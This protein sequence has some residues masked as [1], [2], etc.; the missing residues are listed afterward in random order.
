MSSDDQFGPDVAARYDDDS[1]AMFAPEALEPALDRLEALA[2]GDRRSSLRSAPAASGCRSPNAAFQWPGSSCRR[3]RSSSSAPSPA[4][5]SVGH[6][7][8]IA[9]EVGGP[10]RE[11]RPVAV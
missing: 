3:R 10:S 5:L 11:W 4:A 7:A 8:S 2:A 6:A 1:S 9:H